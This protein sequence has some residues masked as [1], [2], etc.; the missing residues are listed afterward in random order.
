MQAYVN[1]KLLV[2]GP[3]AYNEAG[4]LGMFQLFI[5]SWTNG[6]AQ[7]IP[8][9]NP[10]QNLS[11]IM[12]PLWKVYNSKA[13][14]LQEVLDDIKTNGHRL[15]QSRL[16]NIHE[17]FWVPWNQ[18]VIAA[19]VL[20]KRK[21][22]D[23]L[24]ISLSKKQESKKIWGPWGDMSLYRKNTGGTNNTRMGVLTKVNVNTV[25]KAVN[26]LNP[27]QQTVPWQSYVRW[28]VG[29][30]DKFDG[31]LVD[32]GLEYKRPNSESEEPKDKTNPEKMAYRNYYDVLAWCYA[33][34]VEEKLK[35]INDPNKDKWNVNRYS[36]T[37]YSSL[38]LF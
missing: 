33:N 34:K 19:E 25:M 15:N 14:S 23:G 17:L 21:S 31:A 24:K 38:F 5:S 10:D 9:K 12:I 32:E 8:L 36:R 16:Q 7:E 29:T 28:A 11:T 26:I 1:E 22:G 30:K 13:K 4:A 2:T 27:L 35:S 18:V 6:L 20:M 3:G 37:R